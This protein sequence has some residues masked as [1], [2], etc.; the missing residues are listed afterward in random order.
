MTR[1]STASVARPSKA[2]DGT[3]GMSG[4]ASPMARPRGRRSPRLASDRD[5]LAST[6]E[7]RRQLAGAERNEDRQRSDVEPAADGP[8]E[9]HGDD[10]AG[11]RASDHRQRRARGCRR[12]DRGSRRGSA[13]YAGYRRMYPSRPPMTAPGTI[14][15]TTN[16]RSSTRSCIVRAPIPARTRATKIA[17]ATPSVSQRTTPS[18]DVKKRV[19]VERDH[20]AALGRTR[21][22]RP[23]AET[24]SARG[25]EVERDHGGRHGV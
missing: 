4:P 25:L 23:E 1:S 20:A 7:N 14:P 12:R 3:D 8:I 16:R 10:P 13:K 19:E 15:R 18:P 2:W 6:A 5:A 11:Q 24:P 22:P 21:P 9:Q 17:P